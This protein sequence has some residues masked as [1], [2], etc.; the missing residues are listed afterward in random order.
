MKKLINKGFNVPKINIF[1]VKDYKK[2]KNIII[3]SI[4]LSFKNKI[5]IRSSSIEEDLLG[6]TNAGKYKSFL[7]LNPSNGKKLKLL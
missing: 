3:K 4:K 5:A 6:K 2:N 7:N 1:K